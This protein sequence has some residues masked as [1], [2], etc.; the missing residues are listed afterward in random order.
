MGGFDDTQDAYDNN[1]CDFGDRGSVVEEDATF[2]GE[3][4]YEDCHRQRGKRNVND[5]AFGLTVVAG[6]RGTVYSE[7]VGITREV[8]ENDTGNAEYT[9][10]KE[11]GLRVYIF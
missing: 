10:C 1:K 7:G 4:V 6:S 3:L 5:E 9:G 2:L 11:L 8:A